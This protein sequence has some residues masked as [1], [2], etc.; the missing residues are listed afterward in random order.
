MTVRDDACQSIFEMSEKT[1]FEA[2]TSAYAERLWL[3]RGGAGDH[4]LTA[5]AVWIGDL[6]RTAL[7]LLDQGR[8]MTQVEAAVLGV[9]ASS[10]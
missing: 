10:P 5:N 3:V 1:A 2:L 8:P 9:P 4:E 7:R 6:E